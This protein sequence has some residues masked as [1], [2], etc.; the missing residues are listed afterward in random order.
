MPT[1]FV[2]NHSFYFLT[3]NSLYIFSYTSWKKKKK[4]YIYIYIYNVILSVH[5]HSLN[6]KIT[7]C[8]T[9]YELTG[10]LVNYCCAWFSTHIFGYTSI[11]IT[12]ERLWMWLFWKF[13][14][15][16]LCMI[17]NTHFWIYINNYYL[18]TPLD[19]I[20]LKICSKTVS[21]RTKE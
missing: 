13:V 6:M 20:I 2:V 11:I 4:E 7:R 10:S 12:C 5:V 8:V 19:V 15:K 9:R 1:L 16:L 18:R 21:L 17:F 14:Q 3:T